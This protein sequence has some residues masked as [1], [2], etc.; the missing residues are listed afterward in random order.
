M[1]ARRTQMKINVALR[2]IEVP[3]SFTG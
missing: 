3:I 2:R 1:A